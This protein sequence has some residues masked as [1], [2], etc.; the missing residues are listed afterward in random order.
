MRNTSI[1]S[2]LVNVILYDCKNCEHLPALAKLLHLTSPFVSRSK[3]VKHMDDDSYDVM[4]E[5]AFK[6]LK[7]L[8][9]VELM[10]N[11][12]RVLRDEGHTQTHTCIKAS[13]IIHPLCYANVKQSTHESKQFTFN[14]I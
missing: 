13:I 11:L 10:P 3:N 14:H 8:E 1:L 12:E 6:S 2:G 5:K 9:L 7:I 4:E